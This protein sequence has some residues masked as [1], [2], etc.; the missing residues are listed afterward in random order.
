M[1]LQCKRK[2]GGIWH[3]P[4][5]PYK[6]TH[7]WRFDSTNQHMPLFPVFTCVNVLEE[8]DFYPILHISAPV[9]WLLCLCDMSY[10]CYGHLFHTFNDATWSCALHFVT[11][12]LQISWDAFLCFVMN[13]ELHTYVGNAV[14][15]I[16]LSTFYNTGFWRT[17]GGISFTF[18][19]WWVNR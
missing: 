15:V 18:S 1:F 12:C 7:Q 9:V 11:K 2:P 17:N 13:N 6:P 14:M 5:L 10:V 3:A 19:T 8:K 16:W 4:F